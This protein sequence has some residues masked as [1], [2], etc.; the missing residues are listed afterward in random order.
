METEVAVALIGGAV[1]L[2]V[3]LLELARRQ[4]NKDH[5]SNADKLD[6]I[7]DKIDTVDSR[8]GSHIEWHAHK[9]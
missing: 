3:A 6:R 1:T 8:L 9:D 7:A 4:N 5:A 2:I